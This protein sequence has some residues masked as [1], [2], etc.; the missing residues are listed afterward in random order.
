MA[1]VKEE[2]SLELFL[3]KVLIVAAVVIGLALLWRVR[4]ILLL[5]FIAAVIAAGI[6]PAVQRIRVLWRYW[7]HR[8][9]ARGPAVMIVYLPFVA[10]VVTASLLLVP[11]LVSDFRE[12]SA[13]LPVLIERN[14]VQ[15]LEAYVPMTAVREML[16]E[17]IEI[18][19][20][21][22]FTFMRGAAMTVGAVLAVLFMVAY[23]LIDVHRLRNLIL[24]IYPADVRGERRQTL[25]RMA[26]RMSSWL[27]GQL[28]LA[29]IIGSTTFVGLLLLRVP[30]ALPLAILAAIGETIPVV[31]PIVS[32]LPA[33]AVAILHSPWQF[34]GV[35]LFY[36]LLQKF[37]NYFVVPRVMSRKVSVS[38]LAI[39]IAFMMGAALLG[40]VGAILAIP[41]AAIVQVAFEEVFVSRRERRQ[42]VDRAG[43]LLRRVD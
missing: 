37:E 40:I 13:N 2:R 7:F 8:N 1:Y 22:V 39:I 14:I 20:S 34:W 23:M 9:L 10:V 18:P 25:H 11:R 43:T 32:S 28:L 24:L 26:K 41:I 15:P 16:R 29:L 12:L 35:L 6:A 4:E 36:V 33:L 42:D 5:I 19:Q 3:R 21:S 38:P 30:Y 17:G 27:S 31:G